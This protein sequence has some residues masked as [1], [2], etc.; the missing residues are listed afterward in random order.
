MKDFKPEQDTWAFT[1]Y[2]AEAWYQFN[3]NFWAVPAEVGAT[4][5]AKIGS[6]EGKINACKDLNGTAPGSLRYFSVSA[7]PKVQMRYGQNTLTLT[8]TPRCV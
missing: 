3:A 6:I 8:V 1:R 7:T 4:M 2:D 5:T